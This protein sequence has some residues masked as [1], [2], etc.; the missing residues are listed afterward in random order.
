MTVSDPALVS[1]I[2]REIIEDV[3]PDELPMFGM[4]SRAYLS[5]PERIN[6]S[7]G[8][9]DEMLG[10]GG[11]E[12]EMLTPVIFSVTSAVVSFLV[13]AVVSAAKSETESVVKAQV[14]QMFKRF[15]PAAVAATPAASAPITLTR[16]QLIEVRRVAYD[17]ASGSGLPANQAALLADSTIGQLALVG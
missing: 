10:F 15:T 3:A 4:A 9:A 8:A 7:G 11:G 14:R 2:A 1:D 16:E 6:A 13:A 12:I 17:V 5:N